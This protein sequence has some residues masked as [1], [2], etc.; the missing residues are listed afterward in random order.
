[1]KKKYLV[2]KT[3]KLSIAATLLRAF[4]LEDHQGHK[5][6][7]DDHQGLLKRNSKFEKP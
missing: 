6:K 7:L 2:G 5:K 1:M 4:K 3:P